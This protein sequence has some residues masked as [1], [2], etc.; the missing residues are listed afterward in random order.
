MHV[1]GVPPCRHWMKDLF[2]GNEAVQG[3]VYKGKTGTD[4]ADMAAGILRDIEKQQVQ[5]KTSAVSAVAGDAL[6]QVLARRD[7]K[8][9]SFA[10]T[11]MA[12]KKEARD[13]KRRVSLD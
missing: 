1:P 6:K 11:K 12:E 9:I 8:R 13:N 7:T 10:R 5:M 2:I 4:I 3:K